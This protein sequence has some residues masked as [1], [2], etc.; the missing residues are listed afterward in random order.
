MTESSG[1][2]VLIDLL[3]EYSVKEILYHGEDHLCL[4]PFL[5][6]NGFSL[7]DY[8]CYNTIP[9]FDLQQRQRLCIYDMNTA[10]KTKLEIMIDVFG[11]ARIKELCRVKKHSALTDA[12]CLGKVSK[13]K[14]K[15]ISG[16]FH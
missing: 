5:S 14:Q 7:H 9:F 8:D 12:H 3:S 4:T 16:I 2:K 6:K 10:V 13:T 11:D 15:K 1:A